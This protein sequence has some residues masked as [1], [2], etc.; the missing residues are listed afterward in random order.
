MEVLCRTGKCGIFQLIPLEN[1][2]VTDVDILLD[3]IDIVDSGTLCLMNS[4]RI[5]VID[6]AE[7]VDEVVVFLPHFMPVMY[8]TPCNRVNLGTQSAG[9]SN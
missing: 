6:I 1:I 5:A 8:R 3:D 4:H 7:R 2:P 9:F